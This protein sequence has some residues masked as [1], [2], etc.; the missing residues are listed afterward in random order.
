MLILAP[1]KEPSFVP[2]VQCQHPPPPRFVHLNNRGDF[3]SVRGETSEDRFGSVQIFP[4]PILTGVEFG[5]V[6]GGIG[7]VGDF[8]PPEI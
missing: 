7:S 3:S 1:E 8:G 6:W 5:S 4:G 2:R